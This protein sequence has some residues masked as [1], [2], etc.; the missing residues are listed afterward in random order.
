MGTASAG[1]TRG[2]GPVGYLRDPD[3]A[4]LYNGSYRVGCSHCSRAR[5]F[6]A[7]ALADD[8]FTASDWRPPWSSMHALVWSSV[9][10]TARPMVLRQPPSRWSPLGR[11]PEHRLGTRQYPERL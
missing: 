3:F 2:G 8:R 6:L 5:A 1:S 9:P 11:R 10:P 4:D 7:E